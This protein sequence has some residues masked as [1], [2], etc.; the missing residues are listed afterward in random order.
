MASHATRNRR[1]ADIETLIAHY[2]PRVIDE[3]IDA[4]RKDTVVL[5]S[6]AIAQ[7]TSPEIVAYLQD[8]SSRHHVTLLG[9]VRDPYDHMQ[10]S[11]KQRVK[12]GHCQSLPK[13]IDLDFKTGT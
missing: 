8:L 12:Q 10:S 3:A 7:T 4:S 13:H 2:L 11:W 6:E 9:F 5:S 1:P